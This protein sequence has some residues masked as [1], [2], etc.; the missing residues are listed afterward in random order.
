[1]LEMGMKNGNAMFQRMM[2]WVLRDIENADP[3]VDDI[4]IGSNGDT[5]EELM[6]NHY[7]DIHRVLETLGIQQLIVDPR[8]ANMFMREVEF[9][10]HLLRQR[11]P[12]HSTRETPFHPE[13]DPTLYQ[14][15]TKGIFGTHQLLLILCEKLL[16]SGSTTHGKTQGWQGRWK[17]GIT[18]IGRLG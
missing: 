5:E 14:Y 3:Y 18:E 1:M 7:R 6:E 4:I 11:K 16:E 13:L 12:N 9:C 10:G 8:K 2:E 17:E 15:G